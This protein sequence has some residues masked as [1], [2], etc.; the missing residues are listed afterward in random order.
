MDK[1]KKKM[2]GV[3]D[4]TSFSNVSSNLCGFMEGMNSHLSSIASAFATTQQHEQVLMAREIELDKQKNFF[5]EV[6][7]IPGLTR[8]DAMIAARKL[9]SDTSSL[10][11]FYQCPDD[12]WQKDFVLNLI[13]PDLP[14][15]FTF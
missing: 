15:S 7:K 4:L 10:S 2:S 1:A 13:H 3:V 11:I 14:S 8:I 5:N 9:T 6:I 12:E